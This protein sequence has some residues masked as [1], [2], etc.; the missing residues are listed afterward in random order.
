MLVVMWLFVI[1]W[2]K[3]PVILVMAFMGGVQWYLTVRAESLNPYLS[4]N[5]H[6]Q[7]VSTALSPYS[8]VALTAPFC[9]QVLGQQVT[10]PES[11]Q[12]PAWS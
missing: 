6:S 8:W 11:Y 4:H 12:S 10:P 2:R 5:L 7:V 9:F 1:V 3:C